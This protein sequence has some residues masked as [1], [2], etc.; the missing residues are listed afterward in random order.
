[1][2]AFITDFVAGWMMT[3]KLGVTAGVAAVVAV[4]VFHAIEHLPTAMAW[5]G[6]CFAMIGCS[7]G[8]LIARHENNLEK[9]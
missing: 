1:M 7:I 4:E 8:A 2:R 9:G 3:L 6:I 5:V